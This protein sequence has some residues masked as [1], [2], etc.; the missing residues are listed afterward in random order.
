MSGASFVLLTLSVVWLVFAAQDLWHGN[1]DGAIAGV[2][3]SVALQTRAAL[4]ARASK[5]SP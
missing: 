3:L 2:A 1:L 4:E 5:V